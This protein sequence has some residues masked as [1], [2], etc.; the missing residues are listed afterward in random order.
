MRSKSPSRAPSRSH[1]TPAVGWP[2]GVTR[3][4]HRRF[5]ARAARAIAQHGVD[6][7]VV[8]GEVRDGD[9]LHAPALPIVLVQTYGRT[10][11]EFA[12]RRRR[13]C[14]RPAARRRLG[15][16]F[17]PIGAGVVATKPLGGPDPESRDR[18]YRTRGSGC[19]SRPVP[20]P[21]CRPSGRRKCVSVVAIEPVARPEPHKARAVLCDGEDRALGEA[22]VL[23][24]VTESGG[25]LGESPR[26]SPTI[27]PPT[28]SSKDDRAPRMG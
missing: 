21:R 16:I 6:V 5:R 28:I 25:V 8:A 2:P 1:G 12:H 23:A 9:G 27:D 15:E 11:P 14:A 4:D 10:D 7:G 3:R 22:L 26:L 13:L 24:E 17:K 18:G 19:R 20:R